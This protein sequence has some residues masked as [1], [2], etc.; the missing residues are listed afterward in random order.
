MAGSIYKLIDPRP[1]YSDPDPRYIGKTEKTLKQRLAGHIYKARTELDSTLPK[2]RWIR[3]L[4]AL[5][6][7]P[8]IELIES[9][10]DWSADYSYEREIFWIAYYRAN[11][12]Y[13]LLN[14]A[15]GGRGSIWND[16]DWADEMRARLSASLRKTFAENPRPPHSPERIAQIKAAVAALWSDEERSAPLREQLRQSSLDWWASLTPEERSSTMTREARA[17]QAET[18]RRLYRENPTLRERIAEATRQAMTPDEAKRRG[19]VWT[20]TAAK[21]RGYRVPPRNWDRPCAVCG[22]SLKEYW[23]W[24]TRSCADCKNQLISLVMSGKLESAAEYRAR[25]IREWNDTHRGGRQ[26]HCPADC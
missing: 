10:D 15:D 8:G 23:R 21:K 13:R 24:E 19:A 9:G 2:D 1:E 7:E 3:K 20:E 6:L 18:M 14:I 22:K 25:V 11:G 4:L 5:G 26:E 12:K 17:Q 16:S